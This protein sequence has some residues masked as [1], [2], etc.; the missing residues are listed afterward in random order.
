L[1]RYAPHVRRELAF[2]HNYAIYGQIMHLKA[3]LGASGDPVRIRA[4]VQ[5]IHPE[6]V[7]IGNFVD[8]GENCLIMGTGGV[9]IGNYCI[10]ANHTIIA[11]TSHHMGGLYYRNDYTASVVLGE[12][13]WTGSGVII[14]PGVT[15]GDNSIIGAGAVVTRDI[16]ANKIAV[17]V[18]A[19]PVK[20]V[21]LDPTLRQAHINA[22]TAAPS[23]PEESAP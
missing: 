1:W 19:R 21:P 15:I 9:T 16:P 20:D 5:M 4:G 14:L 7:S 12:N 3:Q 18:P 23:T 13:V 10:L 2:I 6:K 11:T 17:G 22:L 8:I